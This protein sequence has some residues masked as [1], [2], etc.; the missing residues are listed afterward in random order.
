MKL[1]SLVNEVEMYEQNEAV[2]ALLLLESV[3]ES[4]LDESLKDKAKK[5]KKVASQM[6]DLIK[7]AGSLENV[8]KI[9][10]GLGITKSAIAKGDIKPIANKIIS[11]IEKGDLADNKK[12]ALIAKVQA[13]A[14][15][16]ESVDYSYYEDIILDE[17]A[18]AKIK[19]GLKLAGEM[20][21]L[22]GA[23]VTG[24]AGLLALIASFLG[25]MAASVMKFLGTIGIMSGEGA[26]MFING[27]ALEFMSSSVLP[28]ISLVLIGIGMAFLKWMD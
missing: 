27:A 7:K 19:D 23:L 10:S 9:F 13:K 22:G 8:K 4:Q 1:K 17:A 12:Q 2:L 6:K 18:V 25:E 3:D 26:D 11:V 28:L 15:M 16:N 21:K 14:G 20:G 24:G 5:L